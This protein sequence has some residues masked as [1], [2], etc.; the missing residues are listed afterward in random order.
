M[1]HSVQRGLEGGCGRAPLLTA[2]GL[3][4]A[5][6]GWLCRRTSGVCAGSPGDSEEA[7]ETS[8]WAQE[9]GE[10][11]RSQNWGGEGGGRHPR[12]PG[13]ASQALP[14]SRGLLAGAAAVDAC[15][16]PG[17]SPSPAPYPRSCVLPGR[18]CEKKE[19]GPVACGGSAVVSAHPDRAGSAA[20]TRTENVTV[21]GYYPGIIVSVGS[22]GAGSGGPDRVPCG[23]DTHHP[24]PAEV[25]V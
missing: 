14:V 25:E 18:L 9:A 22:L 23:A 10:P 11:S 24:S 5:R 3:T 19:D 8:G 6:G 13:S 21:G 4:E 20:T 15:A 7:G 2:G 16:V 1:R 12:S 17:P